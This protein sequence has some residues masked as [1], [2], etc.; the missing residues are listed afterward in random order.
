MIWG[1]FLCQKHISNPIVHIT[2][3]NYHNKKVVRDMV[4]LLMLEDPCL[5]TGFIWDPSNPS[6]PPSS[7]PL[8]LGLYMD[9]FVYFSKDPKVEALFCR[10]LSERCKV[11]FMG[12]VKWFLGVHFSW[13]ITPS[14]VDVHLNQSGFAT[15]LVKSFALQA[16]IKTPTAT[17]YCS[18]VPIDSIAPSTDAD[19][20]PAQICRKEAF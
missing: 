1:I 3:M 15:N 7:L 19:S 13:R 14:S 4:R 5:Y 12:I 6:A 20:S 18:G 8:S 16:R 17:P 2:K 11:D 10:L 9:D